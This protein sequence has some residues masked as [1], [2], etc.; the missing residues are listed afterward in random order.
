V[1]EGVLKEYENEQWDPY[2]FKDAPTPL[3]VKDFCENQLKLG[4]LR[5]AFPNRE[6]DRDFDWQKQRL[7]TPEEEMGQLM[8][9]LDLQKIEFARRGVPVPGC[10]SS[11]STARIKPAVAGEDARLVR[12]KQSPKRGRGRAKEPDVAKRRAIVAKYRGYTAAQL[13][14]EFDEAHVP[15]PWTKDA[16]DAAESWASAYKKK[17]LRNRI[18]KAISKDRRS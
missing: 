3:L 7:S 12:Q 1:D 8:T 2:P 9:Y 14:E 4:R 18:D 11:V 6:P 16:L 13:C 5:D 15:L 10:E 17:E